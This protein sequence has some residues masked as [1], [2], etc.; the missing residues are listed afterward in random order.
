MSAEPIPLQ[1]EDRAILELECETVAGHTCKVI[2][3]GAG[4]PGLEEVRARVGERLHSVSELSRRLDCSEGEM[5]WVPAEVDLD[6]HVRALE[7]T[8]GEADVA[9]AVGALFEQRL[10]RERPLWQMHVGRLEGGGTLLV[11]RIH[12]AL[13]D[14]TACVRFARELL[15]DPTESARVDRIGVAYDLKPRPLAREHPDNDRRRRHLAAFVEREFGESIR[16]SPF[17]GRIGTRRHIALATVPLAPLH[18]AAKRAADATLNDAVLSLVAGA[19]RRWVTHHHG[20][21]AGVR[22]RVPVSLHH[23]GDT[24]ANRDSFFTLHLPLNEPD[25]IARLR[26]VHHETA[27]RKLDHDA[28][29]LESLSKELAGV[30]PHLDAL[31]RRVEASP[32]NF[33]LSASNVPGPREPV[34]VCGSPVTSMHSLAEIGA[35]HG[36]RIAVVSL[37]GNLHFGLCA[38]PGLVDGLGQMAAGVEAEA[39]A[40]IA[41]ST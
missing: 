27:T 21:L 30:S 16:R 38:D 26:T 11:W 23:E 33:A 19:L 36:L 28:E 29:R 40:L 35:R 1:P 2:R 41:G 15:W 3:L 31:C 14:G 39:E 17:D 9:E 20:T 13:A 12:H 8:L 6:E 4:A 18:D 7:A 37:A 10:D 32:R 25:P 24:V 34:S 5:A 22:V